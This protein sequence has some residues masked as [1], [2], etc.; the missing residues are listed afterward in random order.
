MYKK[1][2]DRNYKI[3]L[4]VA[5]AACVVLMILSAVAASSMYKPNKDS[6]T[7]ELGKNL[8]LL[9]KSSGSEL[10]QSQLKMI[11]NAEVKS[12]TY[13]TD[14][15]GNKLF[16]AKIRLYAPSVNNGNYTADPDGYI[17]QTAASMFEGGASE[18][19]EIFGLCNDN[20]PVVDVETISTLTETAERVWQNES[21]TSDKNFE[22]AITDMIIPEPFPDRILTEGGQYQPV[23]DKWL[24]DCAAQFASE[25]L[26]VNTGGELSGDVNDIRAA[27]EQIITPYLC[28]VRNVSI[29]RSADKKGM[30]TLSFDSLDIIGTLSTASKPSISAINK[31]AGVYSDER[32]LKM[33]IDIDVSDLAAEGGKMKL[34]FFNLIKALTKYGSSVGSATVKIK[35]PTSSQ[36]I[37]GKSNGTWPVEFKR[38]KGDGNVIIDVIRVEESGDETPVIKLFLTDGGS[39]PVCL[40]KGKYR[41]NIAVGNTFY[42]GK[43]LFGINGIYMKDTQNTYSIPSKN[44]N[45]ITVAKQPGESLSFT[46]YLIGQSEDPSLIDKSQF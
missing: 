28:S 16:Y 5:I 24:T 20:S 26:K 35:T 40:S 19:C 27:M 32:S 36:I 31:L 46:D 45:S 11:E 10:S 15:F 3:I 18:E 41:L 17:F 21:L 12:V 43:E 44:I 9:C 14:S 6:F 34:P 23:Y 13:D 22:Y 38:K 30:L 25:G 4:P 1:K 8:A 33:S 29:E 7:S 2:I 37:D 39:I 42:G